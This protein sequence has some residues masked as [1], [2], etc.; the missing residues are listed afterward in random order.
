[1]IILKSRILK[2]LPAIFL[3]I[4]LITTLGFTSG[5]YGDSVKY[6]CSLC[7]YVYDPEIEGVP[8]EDLPDEW[9]CPGTDCLGT[10]ADLVEIILVTWVCPY[11]GYVYDP[12]VE[13]V[14]FEDLPDD[15]T[16]PG[17]KSLKSDFV[18]DEEYG[19]Y[20]SSDPWVAHLQHV[21]AMKSKHLAV[22]QRVIEAHKAKDA[23]HSSIPGLENA[24][25]SSSKS[26]LKAKDQI[27]AYLGNLSGLGVTGEENTDDDVLILNSED[28][29][30]ED[31]GNGNLNGNNGNG[32]GKGNKENKEH[33]NN[34]KAKGKNK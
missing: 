31:T 32:N 7:G 22:L 34:G 15:W 16:C 20:I 19:E 1:V 4:A 21:L 2:I 17:C 18:Q 10:K 3:V 13:G 26:V 33:K 8:F 5:L 14:P 27:D 12:E 29:D 23:E 24:F 11:C 6:E 28:N 25:T 9:T 30:D